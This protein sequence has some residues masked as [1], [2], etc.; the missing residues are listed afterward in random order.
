MPPSGPF[1]FEAFGWAEAV[2]TPLFMRFWFLGTTRTSSCRTRRNSRASAAQQVTK[3]EVI[4]LYYDYAK[5]AGNGALL[6]G[7]RPSSLAL[8]P[9]WRGP[10]RGHRRT[11]MNTVR[12][13]GNWGCEP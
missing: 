8:E 10:A 13:T 3:E 11:R 4:K 6:P 5:G 2:Y 1:L 7:R 9:D 12:R